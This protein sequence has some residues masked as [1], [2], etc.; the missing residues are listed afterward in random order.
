MYENFLFMK[1]KKKNLKYTY[2]IKKYLKL[3]L[4]NL[5]NDFLN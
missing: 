4:D 3:I 2:I 5:L 1:I